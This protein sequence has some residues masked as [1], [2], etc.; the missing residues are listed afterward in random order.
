MKAREA[1]NELVQNERHECV[2]QTAFDR[3][4]CMPYEGDEPGQRYLRDEAVDGSLVLFLGDTL[5]S[6]AIA[7]LSGSPY[8]HAGLVLRWGERVLLIEAATPSVHVKPLSI[9]VAEYRGVADLYVPREPLSDEVREKL[10]SVATAH[11]AVPFGTVDLA[12]LGLFTLIRRRFVERHRGEE[13]L[14]CSEFIA[15]VYGRAGESLV[16]TSIPTCGNTSCLARS[17]PTLD[18]AGAAEESYASSVAPAQLLCSRRFEPVGRFSK[19][20]LGD[21]KAAR[22]RLVADHTQRHREAVRSR[23]IVDVPELPQARRRR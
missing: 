20:E 2:A 10:I 9:S 11:L 3:M 6:K 13:D 5:V 18:G 16:G 21:V 17:R 15:R 14:V 23:R 19:K 12:W 7:S 4:R 8:S 1:P 22:E